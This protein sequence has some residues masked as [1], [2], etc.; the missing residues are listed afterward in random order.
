[1]PSN[2]KKHKNSLFKGDSENVNDFFR[3]FTGDNILIKSENNSLVSYP[4]MNISEET[5]GT[6][7]RDKESQI[8]RNLQVNKLEIER[9]STKLGFTPIQDSFYKLKSEDDFNISEKKNSS[10]QYNENNQSNTISL[11]DNLKDIKKSFRTFVSRD[12]VI[13]PVKMNYKSHQNIVKG[14]KISNTTLCLSSEISD[15]ISI[16]T[17]NSIID[18]SSKI[19]IYKD[20][21]ERIAIPQFRSVIMNKLNN[22]SKL[23]DVNKSGIINDYSVVN[24]NKWVIMF[25]LSLF[26]VF[27]VIIIYVICK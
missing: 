25:I 21:Y 2:N 15:V 24:K 18:S 7:N 16:D 1:M 12:K 23:I 17:F 4:I 14:H 3:V 27:I 9:D 6:E 13:R 8:R 22:N 26:L 11:N 10:I 19:K 5:R 20:I